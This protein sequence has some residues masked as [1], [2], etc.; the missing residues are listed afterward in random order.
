MQRALAVLSLIVVSAGCTDSGPGAAAARAVLKWDQFAPGCVALI[1]TDAEDAANTTRTTFPLEGARQGQKIVAVFR[2]ETWSNELTLTAQAY[3]GGCAD[4]KLVAEQ[5]ERIRLVSSVVDATFS[6]TAKDGD[7]DGFVDA[8]AQL[9]GSDCNDGLA[10]VFPGATETCNGID[11]DCDAEVDDGVGSTFYRDQ[12]QDGFGIA[13]DSQVSCVA[14]DGYAL[15]DGDCDDTRAQVNPN[16]TEICNALDDNCDGNFD[17]G[18][19]QNTYYVDADEDGF[20]NAQGSVQACMPPMGYV[21]NSDDCDDALTEVRPGAT[22]VCNMRDDDCNGTVDE[23]TLIVYFRDTDMDG[24]GDNTQTTSACMLPSGYADKGGDCDDS[25]GDRTPGRVESCD[26]K[27]NDCDTVVDEGVTT[28]YYEDLDT[29][30]YGNSFITT[31]ACALPAGHAVVGNDCDDNDAARSPGLAEVC[32]TKD[33]NCDMIVDEGVTQTFYADVDGDTFGDGAVTVAACMTPMGYVANNTDCDDDNAQINPGA[34]EACNGVDDDCDT[35]I[36]ENLLLTF[37]ADDD[38]DGDGNLNAPLQACSAGPGRSSTS[39]DCDDGN[40]FRKTGLAETCDGMDNDCNTTVDDGMVCSGYSWKSRDTAGGTNGRDWNRI[41]F[42]S[43]GQIWAAGYE[44]PL[45]TGTPKL[46][47]FNGGTLVT[48]ADQDC[49]GAWTSAWANPANGAVYVGGYNGQLGYRLNSGANCTASPTFGNQS[50]RGLV[51]FNSSN[52]LDVW[53]VNV[54]GNIFRWETWQSTTTIVNVQSV[55]GTWFDMDASSTNNMIVVGANNSNAPAILRRGASGTFAMETLPSGLP[56]TAAFR[57]VS[58]WPASGFTAAVGD[59]GMVL[60]RENKPNAV[61][62]APTSSPPNVNNLLSVAA[63]GKNLI[64]VAG[65]STGATTYALWRWDGSAWA[66]VTSVSM[67][68]AP[69]DLGGLTPS[70]LW[71]VGDNGMVLQWAP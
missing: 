30:G 61:W 28:T 63:Y 40:P 36:D 62:T 29:D 46:R 21:S 3:E 4:G 69:E 59:N 50:I 43:P 8:Q 23:G 12:D 9:P 6:L 13:T 70:D 38:R 64:Y 47:S 24:F 22:E 16:G 32:D 55:P 19:T 31:E 68:S 26:M 60:Y 15:Q 65:T 37:Y 17:E 45:S 11:D 58:V 71:I 7:E 57:S 20:G 52:G 51:G 56:G 53:G 10:S 39:T 2:G 33:N 34:T 25:D 41:G 18:F 27:D 1:A 14:P 48:D 35:Q 42:I 67:P 66:E 5:E 49:G 54:G 44:E